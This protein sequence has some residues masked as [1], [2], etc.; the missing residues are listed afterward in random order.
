[1]LNA[2]YF[3]FLKNKPTAIFTF[4]DYV[5]LD[6]VQA[7][8]K[9]KLKINRDISFVS[10][11]NIPI[12]NYSAH[13]PLASGEQFSYQQAQKDMETMFDL[14]TKKQPENGNVTFYKIKTERQLV[15]HTNIKLQAKT[16]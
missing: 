15:S 4:N 10:Y 5:V 6:A 11:V 13:P 1:M 14:L 16:K 9:L 8:K 3:F 2:I 7:T 12:S